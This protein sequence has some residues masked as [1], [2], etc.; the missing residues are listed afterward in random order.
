MKLAVI[1]SRK[2]TER[3]DSY[4][5]DGI[6][7]LISGG[8]V[9]VDAQVRLFARKN[10]IPLTEIRPDYAKYGRRAPLLRNITI[11]EK[12]DEVYAFWDGKSRG[13]LFV[14]E[15]CRAM[16]KP[17][18]VFVDHEE[19]RIELKNGILVRN[20]QTVSSDSTERRT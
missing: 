5:P 9:G 2:I 13:T 17:V 19:S 15:K 6:T 10:G 14:I 20:S 7:E 3:I 11:I 12:A 18:R 1:G 8:A 16:H 4:L